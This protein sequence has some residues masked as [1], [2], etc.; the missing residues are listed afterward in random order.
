MTDAFR[1]TRVKDDAC[2]T[3]RLHPLDAFCLGEVR[4]AAHGMVTEAFKKK[5]GDY[6]VGRTIGEVW[7]VS[8]LHLCLDMCPA[9]T[10]Y[11]MCGYRAPTLK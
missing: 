4:C 5:I 8:H 2:V 9:N 7:D 1:P 6:L 3:K 11:L 10:V